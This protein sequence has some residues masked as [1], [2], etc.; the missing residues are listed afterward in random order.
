MSTADQKVLDFCT[1]LS[2]GTPTP[3]GG[4]AAA[5]AGAM[6]A[7]LV[8]MVA[9]LTAGREKFAAVNDEMVSLQEMGLREAQSFL[10]CAD[11]DAD[12]F[13]QVMAGLALPK[14]TDEEKAARRKAVQAGYKAATES[15]LDTMKHAVVVMRGALAAASK[16][17]P[18]ALSD[19]YVGFLMANAAFEGA[20]WNVCINLPSLKDEAFKEA[21][22]ADVARL[23]AD[24]REIADAMVAL[25]PDPVQ[26]FV[27]PK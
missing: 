21:I 15:P 3:G 23:R 20:L 14:G 27:A 8:A 1:Q 12:A 13:N 9:G 10:G 11:A 7:S 24:Q 17:N 26:R 5:V 2:A 25:T 18:N 4:A 19:G 22:L 16:G 6:G